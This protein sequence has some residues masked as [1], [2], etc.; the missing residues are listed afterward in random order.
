MDSGVFRCVACYYTLLNWLFRYCQL[1]H[2]KINDCTVILTFLNGNVN[3]WCSLLPFSHAV[4]KTTNNILFLCTSVLFIT[5]CTT[6]CSENLKIK[7]FNVHCNVNSCWK[8]ITIYL[9]CIIFLMNWWSLNSF[10][11]CI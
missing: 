7:K 5:T 3:F 4:T 10:T 6:Y 8:Q 11:K 1:M 2:I 9:W